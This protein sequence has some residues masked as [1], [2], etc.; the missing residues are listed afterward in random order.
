MRASH[1]S[2]QY[3]GGT[4]KPRS[5]HRLLLLLLSGLSLAAAPTSP[6]HAQTVPAVPAEASAP[7][8]AF[9]AEASQ[10]FG[11][12]VA[13]IRALMRV[14]SANDVRAVSVKGAMGLMQIMPD[15][16]AE[17][18]TRYR[19]GPDAF[20]PRDNILAGT[21]Y[22]RELYDKYGGLPLGLQCRA[23]ALRGIP[24]RRSRVASGNTR[25][26]RPA[27]PPCRR[28]TDG[29][30]C[31][32][33]CR[34]SLGMDARTAFHRCGRARFGV[35]SSA[36]RTAD[37]RH[38]H[39]GSI[40][41]CR[42]RG[43]TDRRPFHLPARFGRSPMSRIARHRATANLSAAWRALGGGTASTTARW[44]DKRAR[45][46]PWFGCAFSRTYAAISRGAPD[47]RSLRSGASFNN[48]IGFARCAGPQP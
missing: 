16:W 33:G 4:R 36:A 29:C 19:L 37:A 45:C 26:C 21:A 34:R 2:Q 44:Q 18:H 3:Q 5:A 15:T 27:R 41:S 20:D 12:P 14:E 9:V 1:R 10:R 35:G 6:G 30:E 48:F 24:R 22:L 47:R 23:R 43:D 39:R 7:F 42:G 40:A 13:W 8:A 17:L 11:I 25:L 38:Q 32:S 31:H 28:R 46:A